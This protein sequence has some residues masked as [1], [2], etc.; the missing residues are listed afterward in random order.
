MAY[1]VLWSS[2]AN[3]NISFTAPYFINPSALNWGPKYGYIWFPS[4]LIAA[5]FIWHFMPEI[6]NRSL[7]E[8]SEMFEAG[9]PARKF[10]GYKCMG[11]ATATKG[12]IEEI[13]TNNEPSDEK[14][15]DTTQ[16][17]HIEEI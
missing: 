9:L 11:N 10:K 15:L 1:E 5:A 13:S 6:H 3:R 14:K 4:C 8:I 12:K 7:E 2:L 16:V 17:E